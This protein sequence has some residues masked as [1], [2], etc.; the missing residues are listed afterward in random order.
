MEFL[1]DDGRIGAGQVVIAVDQMQTPFAVKPFE[2]IENIEVG[3]MNVGKS[4]IF[5]QFVPVADF[6]VGVAVDAGYW[7]AGQH[8]GSVFKTA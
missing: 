2:Q 1:R 7:S 4:A 8:E 3:G 5:E 6:H